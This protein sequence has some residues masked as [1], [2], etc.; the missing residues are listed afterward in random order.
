MD[1]DPTKPQAPPPQKVEFTPPLM[2]ISMIA[3]PCIII[4]DVIAYLLQRST[5]MTC[6]DIPTFINQS[7]LAAQVVGQT[8][9]SLR[10]TIAARS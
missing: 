8:W 1:Q 9:N 4:F 3:L 5:C 10:A 2:A 7:S 6:N